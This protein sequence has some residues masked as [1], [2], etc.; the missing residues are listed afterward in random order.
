MN[1]L[2]TL[3]LTCVDCGYQR[4]IDIQI[5]KAKWSV[6]NLRKDPDKRWR[7]NLQCNPCKALEIRQKLEEQ[8][9]GRSA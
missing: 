9:N 4:D 6:D 8:K 5:Q 2:P 1:K 3:R 7:G